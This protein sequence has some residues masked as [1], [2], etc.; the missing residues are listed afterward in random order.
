MEK[1]GLQYI[2]YSDAWF[3]LHCIKALLA[4]GKLKEP[5]E[6]QKRSLSTII[7]QK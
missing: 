5:T 3:I 6:E 4:N 2:F 7:I 1:Y